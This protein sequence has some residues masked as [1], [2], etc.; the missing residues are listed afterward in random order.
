[1]KRALQMCL[2]MLVLLMQ[3]A[4]L[5]IAA[6]PQEKKCQMACCAWLEQAGMSDCTCAEPSLPNQNLPAPLPPASEGRGF[7][8]QVV[9]TE[10]S[11]DFQF[12]LFQAK[13]TGCTIRP[14]AEERASTWP[15]VR[16]SVLH[17]SLL[18]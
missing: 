4:P 6:S 12:Y 3:T 9:W 10:L 8:P 18:T 17:C 11:Q 16:L 2:M 7:T 13:Q 1:M 5:L 15:H 14:A